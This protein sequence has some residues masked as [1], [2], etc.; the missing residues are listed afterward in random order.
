LRGSNRRF[1]KDAPRRSRFIIEVITDMVLTAL[2]LMLILAMFPVAPLQS[3]ALSVSLGAQ[4]IIG[5]SLFR[6]L[7]SGLQMPDSV[8]SAAG[9]VIGPPVV[10]VAAVL[11]GVG[12]PRALH[13]MVLLLMALAGLVSVCRPIDTTGRDERQE[14]D[15]QYLGT[16]CLAVTGVASFAA[17]AGFVWL[18]PSGIGFLAASVFVIRS[19]RWSERRRIAFLALATLMSVTAGRALMYSHYGLSTPRDAVSASSDGLQFEAWSESLTRFGPFD[20]VMKAGTKIAYHWLSFA[21]MGVWQELA[22][23]DPWVTSAIGLNLLAAV[24]SSLVVFVW[25]NS[26]RAERPRLDTPAWMLLVICSASLFESAVVLPFDSPSQAFSIAPMTFSLLLWFRFIRQTHVGKSWIG[27]G[28]MLV[29]GSFIVFLAKSSTIIPMLLVMVVST[30]QVLRAAQR[31]DGLT[32]QTGIYAVLTIIA[33]SA[34]LGATYWLFLFDPQGFSWGRVKLDLVFWHLDENAV[35]GYLSLPFASAWSVL[36][37][38]VLV[39]MLRLGGGMRSFSY[40]E[41]VDARILWVASALTVPIL[42]VVGFP[43]GRI[44]PNFVGAGAV[45]SGLAAVSPRDSLNFDKRPFLC[46][47]AG[48]GVGG[49]A[50]GTA[51]IALL[52]VHRLSAVTVTVLALGTVASIASSMMLRADK[53]KSGSLW[54]IFGLVCLTFNLGLFFSTVLRGPIREWSERSQNWTTSAELA[55]RF[56]NVL[57][58][59]SAISERL[60]ELSDD[61]DIVASTTQPDELPLVSTLT[62]RRVLAERHLANYFSDG[63]AMHSRVVVQDIYGD[64]GAADD[65]FVLNHFYCVKWFV[66]FKPSIL[67]AYEAPARVV[68]RDDVATLI[69]FPD[70]PGGSKCVPSDVRARDDGRGVSE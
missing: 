40:A 41:A 33:V 32:R 5:A 54:S 60:Q 8:A 31:S 22:A 37:V 51:S 66:A 10:S 27:P 49:V 6:L 42:L 55:E 30:L 3:L 13:A 58:G 17:A 62:A 52:A 7:A 21:V 14:W 38:G 2:P 28:L 48:A 29:L 18:L 39:W 43:E 20:D 44:A 59:S 67:S 53:L 23:S 34:V 26:Q 1:L 69:E 65:L 19:A 68:Y 11:L 64:S 15:P 12:S 57:D 45:L 47:L 16:T 35:L 24:A 70:P 63:S 36:V 9:V 25:I 61:T 50:V 46:V 4:V 56:D